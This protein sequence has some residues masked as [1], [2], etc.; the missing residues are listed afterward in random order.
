[1]LASVLRERSIDVRCFDI[2]TGVYAAF[3]GTQSIAEKFFKRP[4][5]LWD[6]AYYT[7]W[8][9]RERYLKKTLPTIRSGLQVYIDSI[10]AYAPTVAA[11]SIYDTTRLTSLYVARA[12]KKSLPNIKIIFGGPDCLLEE[13]EVFIEAIKDVVDVVVLGEGERSIVE[14]AQNYFKNGAF[15]IVSGTMSN[16]NGQFVE[17]APRTL[18]EDLDT[19]PFP[20]FSDFELSQY[21][22]PYSLP[23]ARSRGC[24][25][26]CSFCGE[27]FYWQRYRVRSIR[28]TIEEM[29]N[30]IQRYGCRKFI[31]AD[32][33]LNADVDELSDFADTLIEEDLNIDWGGYL[34]IHPAMDRAFFDRLKRAGCSYISLG[35]ESGCQKVVNDM[36]KGFNLQVARQN[37]KD[38][39]EAG[40]YT[41]VCWI[42]GFPTETFRD[43]LKGLVFVLRVRKYICQWVLGYLSCKIIPHTYLDLHRKEYGVSKQLFLGEWYTEDYK[44]TIVHRS[45]RFF[46]T[47]VF[48]FFLRMNT[49]LK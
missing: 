16:H 2:N 20:D 39:Y 6:P 41:S 13:K 32:S 4:S 18:I 14:L 15:G 22:Q 36:K 5:C 19:L 49:A 29:K 34:R 42:I 38:A 40:L 30:G 35:I 33:L 26:H 24:I 8:I 45:I 23:L 3:L 28:S 27:S 1:M 37:L 44:N 10:I 9:R 25:G 21:S 43:F 46:I 7:H 47:R 31:T 17:Y 11:F 48:A 12:L